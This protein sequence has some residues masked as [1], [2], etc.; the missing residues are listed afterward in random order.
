MVEEIGGAVTEGAISKM[1]NAAADEVCSGS[2]A[3]E[4]LIDAA[5]LL[6]VNASD[7]ATAPRQDDLA[8]HIR[9]G[10]YS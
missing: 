2:A 9:E 1:L 7:F 3:A 5:A 4:F 8:N 10:L 6:K